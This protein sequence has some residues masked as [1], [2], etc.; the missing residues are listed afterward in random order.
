MAAEGAAAV[1]DAATPALP[2]AVIAEEA[3]ARREEAYAGACAAATA[4][5]PSAAAVALRAAICAVTL[6]CR[7]ATEELTALAMSLAE[8]DATGAFMATEAVSVPVSCSCRPLA[9]TVGVTVSE[10]GSIASAAA[11]DASHAAASALVAAVLL[12]TA[13]GSESSVVETV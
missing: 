13:G 5:A 7:A 8:R 4:D 3:A 1:S 2:A 6:G 12:R 10:A 9:V 11:T